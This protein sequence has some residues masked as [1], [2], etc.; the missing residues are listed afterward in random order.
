[1]NQTRHKLITCILPKGNAVNVAGKLKAEHGI[2]SMN[3]NNARGV[4]KITPL[5]Y[6]G[7]GGQSE[8]EIL[9]VVIPESDADEIFEYI[10]E[11]ANIN[12]PHG[13][14]MYIHP[15][16]I[17]TPFILPAIPDEK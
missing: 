1:M 11:E 14:L 3:I 15:L 8:K 10:Y 7:I 12:R 4:G 2:M 13:G 17:S 6:R 9:T 5:A 16:N